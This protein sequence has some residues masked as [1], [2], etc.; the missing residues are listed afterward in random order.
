MLTNVFSKF[1]QAVACRDQLAKTV[2]QCL[3]KEWFVRFGVPKMIH[4]DRGRN[5]ESALIAELCQIYG[6][7][8]SRTTA[9][10][11]AGNGQCERFNRTLHDRLR[12]LLREKKNRWPQYLPEIT[13]AY[14]S[15]PHSS[16]GYTPH[17]LFFGRE[18]V[19]PID[20]YLGLDDDNTD[21]C[22]DNLDEWVA[23]HY[24]RIEDAFAKASEN[25]EKEAARRNRLSN[26]NAEDISLPVWAGVFLKDH[27]HRGRHKI[28]NVWSSV[29]HVVTGRPFPDG[30]VY[31]VKLTHGQGE[32]KTVNRVEVRDASHLPL[33]EGEIALDDVADSPS[34]ERRAV[35]VDDEDVDS[36]LYAPTID[37]P[38]EGEVN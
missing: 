31:V 11:P 9:Y 36:L 14:N 17:F 16:T 2:A 28:Q 1:T 35:I 25:T 21:A 33:P 27:S 38:T 19:L 32:S 20:R 24:R 37:T 30:N 29:P 12:T 4:S 8:K 10:H 34:L 15:T 13:Y 7:K 22:T 5:F 3:V 6:V 26:Q 18:P 23:G